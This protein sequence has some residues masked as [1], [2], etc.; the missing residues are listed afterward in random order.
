MLA[1]I[2]AL[3]SSQ[4]STETMLMPPNE[5]KGVLM[6]FYR[7]LSAVAPS[8]DEV[9]ITSEV[10]LENGT[11][12]ELMMIEI[13]VDLTLQGRVFHSVPIQ[14]AKIPNSFMPHHG[15]LLPG[16]RT[17]MFNVKFRIP[18]KFYAK[19]VYRTMR[20][21]RVR[22]WNSKGDLHNPAH[23]FTMMANT[24]T[25]EIIAKFKK[26]PSLM[27]V[28]SS[29]GMTPTL[30]AFA[31]AD[32]DAVKALQKLGGN[33]KDRTTSGLSAMFFAVMNGDPKNLAYAKAVGCNINE[34]L[35]N[36]KRTP[37][38]LAAREGRPA[39]TKW[40]LEN[41][42]NPNAVDADGMTPL[43]IAAAEGMTTAFHELVRHKANPRAKDKNGYGAMHYGVLYPNFLPMIK[44]AGVS[45][46]D[47]SPKNGDTPAIYGCK[48][49]ADAGV[50]WLMKNGADMNIKDR[51]GKTAAYYAAQF[52]K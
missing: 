48:I 21:G 23:L 20:I 18:R 17:P 26:D 38:F 16:S 1:L 41:G 25:P 43:L 46:N 3:V 31:M 36:S 33:P 52:G 32:P 35:P 15:S 47:V 19:N 7:F 29:A 5:K 49:G 8:K 45:V 24:Y 40:L 4:P 10:K 42:A 6:R 27:K 11:R 39:A 22:V 37:L 14:I 51:A 12:R 44:A 50:A 13:V 30:M 28:R 9:E 2:V 34:A